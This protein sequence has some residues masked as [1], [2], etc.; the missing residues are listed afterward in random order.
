MFY[1][2]TEL[3]NFAFEKSGF[4]YLIQLAV[5]RD[6]QIKNLISEF[7]PALDLIFKV[8]NAYT[9]LKQCRHG[10]L[11]FCQHF[12]LTEY[13]VYMYIFH[14]CV[15]FNCMW[16]SGIIANED[17]NKEETK[18]HS[19]VLLSGTLWC[20]NRSQQPQGGG[21]V[22]CWTSPCVVTRTRQHSRLR[23]V[24]AIPIRPTCTTR[25]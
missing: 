19:L 6:C 13:L 7:S 20:R 25:L 11:S 17:L 12:F 15:M 10:A 4:I 18:N 5:I 1:L 9:I 23:R 22:T 24:L 3:V 14:V 21:A 16:T 8:I 2:H